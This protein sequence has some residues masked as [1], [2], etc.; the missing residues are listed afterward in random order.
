L[1]STAVTPLQLPDPAAA[2]LCLWILFNSSNFILGRRFPLMGPVL[3]FPCPC[4]PCSAQSFH[5]VFVLDSLVL[6]AFSAG[7]KCSH[8]QGLAPYLLPPSST[9]PRVW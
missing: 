7:D 9:P 1:C 5:T 4:M 8:A 6:C 3:L 2:G